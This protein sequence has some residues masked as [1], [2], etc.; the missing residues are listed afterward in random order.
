M[1]S[2]N[3]RAALK[4]IN[5]GVHQD[6]TADVVLPSQYF[7]S[8]GARTFSREQ[9]LMLAVLIDAIN[10]VL[11]ENRDRSASREA[12]SWIFTSGVAKQ[13]SFDF[14][15]DAVGLNTEG[16][17]IRLREL[18]SHGGRLR[19]IKL[20]EQGRRRPVVKANRPRRR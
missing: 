6:L 4:P 8:V 3:S 12:A 14:A 2:A 18:A 16:L 20:R 19:R 17:R 1:E 10:L 13:L 15:C 5:L 11:Q 7:G 9:R